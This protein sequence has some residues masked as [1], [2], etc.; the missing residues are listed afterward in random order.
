M[1][2]IILI[3]RVAAG[4]TTLTQALR[5]EDIH[6]Y[7]TQYI[8]YLDTIIDTPGEYTE[9]RQTSGALALYAYEAD[10][11]GLVLSANEP[12]SIFSPC[13]TSLVNRE[14]V[15]IITGIDK[16]DANVERVERWLRLAGCKKI[17]PLSAY[18]GE[19][20]RELLNYLRE[21]GDPEIE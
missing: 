10:I 2:K 8:N 11:V 19:G 20:I 14:V 4:K 1:K 6:Y 18:T 17:F 21:E 15:G 9:L 3:G 12:Y 7:K 5:G 16:P 13:I